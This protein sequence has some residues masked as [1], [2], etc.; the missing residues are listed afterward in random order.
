M[1]GAKMIKDSDFDKKI[2]KLC[3][4]YE[5]SHVDLIKHLLCAV[6]VYSMHYHL[7]HGWDT[8]KI[9]SEVVS[10]YHEDSREDFCEYL[11][12]SAFILEKIFM[13]PYFAPN[14]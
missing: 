12:T 14:D 4:E 2:R 7:L 9:L 10:A 11:E 13:D 1:I 8:E 3:K 5:V 6:G